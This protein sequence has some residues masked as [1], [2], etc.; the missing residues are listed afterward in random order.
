M[1]WI[2]NLYDTYDAC[3]GVVGVSTDGQGKMLL[4]LGHTL[5][6]TDVAI[7][8]RS[9][10]MFDRAEKS[11]ME[12]CS[13]CTE[14]SESR[15]ISAKDSPHPLFD[16]VKYL[17][18]KKYLENLGKW[19]EYLRGNPKH[20][21]AHRMLSAVYQ[22]VKGLTV[23]CDIESCGIKT[24]DEIFVRFCVNIEEQLENRLWMLPEMWVAW[25][26]FY[27]AT[28]LLTRKTKG[29]C[30]IS[31][32]ANVPYTEKHPKSINRAVGNAKLITGND[33]VNYT[34]RGRFEV[35]TQAV[36]VSYEASQKAHQ[37]LR[38]L[39]ANY[40]YRCDTQAIVSWAVDKAPSILDHFD[41]SFGIYE[42]LAVTDSEKLLEASALIA[43][44]YAHR[45]KNAL[46]SLNTADKLRSYARRVAVIAT[47]AATTGRMS[48]TYYRELTEGE[49][50]E[51]VIYWHNTCKWYQPFYNAQSGTKKFGYFIG[52]PSFDRITEA[53]LGKRRKKKDDSYDKLKKGIRERLLHCI[54]DGERIPLDMVNAVIHRASNPL[55]LER[56]DTKNAEERWRDWDQILCVACAIVKRY[57]HEKREEYVV[58]LEESRT[59]R[60]Y[61]Y[62]RLLALADRIESA[63]R[64]KQGVSKDDARATNAI[65][66]M[67]AFSQHPLR[68]WNMLLT[69]QLNPHIQQLKGADWYMSQIGNIMAL[70]EAGHFEDDTP[71]SGTYLLG[72]FAQRQELRIKNE[73]NN[74]EN[75]G[76]G[77]EL[78]E[79]N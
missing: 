15:T 37:A 56:A 72:F 1:N 10:G 18:D 2:R 78:N 59:D 19:K 74:N 76:E 17:I 33:N 48:V 65:R 50:L 27:N 35:P 70:F 60:D 23:L 58:V 34:Y 66:Y 8:L 36:T 41:D 46:L 39:I 67:T 42:S 69:Q 32:N 61:L 73:N 9:N 30:Y 55:A 6:N 45:L 62:G 28:V 29:L 11:K 16:Q 71:L 75:G 31:G 24:D 4:P 26:D 21:M 51:H 5:K 44:D 47:D 63:A 20:G 64:Y 57:Y 77:N 53:V 3:S 49:Y 40:G 14:D 79:K 54:F 12:V 25:N 43:G 38:W 13:P 68:T 52:A 22:Y 7:Y